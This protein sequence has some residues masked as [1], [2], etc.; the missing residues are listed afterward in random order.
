MVGRIAASLLL[1]AGQSAAPAPTWKSAQ[2]L[3]VITAP[4]WKSAQEL[5]V[6][7]SGPWPVSEPEAGG[8]LR[9]LPFAAKG[10]VRSTIY[11]ASEDTAGLAVRFRSDARTLLINASVTSAGEEMPHMPASGESGFDLYCFDPSSKSYRWLAL[12]TPAG[13]AHPWPTA[14][15]GTLTGSAP[16]PALEGGATREFILYLP[17]YNGVKYVSIGVEGPASLLPS[18]TA[19]PRPAPV[20]VYGTSITQGGVVSRPGMAWTNIVGRSLGR[21]VL[22]FGYSGQGY[23]EI[24]V[25]TFLVKVEDAGA[26]VIDCNPNMAHV[27]WCGLCGSQDPTG[28][29]LCSKNAGGHGGA[30]PG[31]IRN[32]T[33]PLVHSMRSRGHPTTPIVLSEGTRCE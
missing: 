27:D 26:F 8:M 22:N 29:C 28:K 16:L 23:M 9:R 5:T 31:G 4:T 33:V 17:L 11:G 3:T 30:G 7:N 21:N 20:V 25:A 15:T 10:V 32:R 13:H 6:I 12:W 24:S 19:S 1:L 14:A 2:E 18:P